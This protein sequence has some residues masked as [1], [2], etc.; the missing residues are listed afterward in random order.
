MRRAWKRAF[1]TG[2]ALVLAGVLASGCSKAGAGDDQSANRAPLPEDMPACAD[3]FADGKTV[4]VD[5]FGVACKGENGEL[6]VPRP[7]NLKCTDGRVFLWNKYA[8]GFVDDQ[9]TMVKPGINDRDPVDQS[10][11]CLK[12]SGTAASG[13]GGGATTTTAPGDG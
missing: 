2:A 1:S 8:F 4:E 5:S 3:L 11:E 7:V 12:Q 9:M 10:M 13:G 6:A